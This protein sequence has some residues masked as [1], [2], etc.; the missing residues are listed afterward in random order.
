MLALGRDELDEAEKDLEKVLDAKPT[1]SQTLDQLADICERKN[2]IQGTYT[3]TW[4][5]D[6]INKGLWLS[7]DPQNANRTDKIKQ[8]EEKMRAT[9]KETGG[10]KIWKS[11]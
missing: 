2:D 10:R 7:L 1:D 6:R 4:L 9:I 11:L 8:L 3:Y 5:A